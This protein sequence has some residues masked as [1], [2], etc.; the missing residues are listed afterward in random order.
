MLKRMLQAK[1][2]KLLASPC[3]TTSAQWH[4]VDI[5][6]VRDLRCSLHKLFLSATK[7]PNVLR[8]SG[9]GAF[10]D[11]MLDVSKG[12]P[13]LTGIGILEVAI[14]ASPF[15]DAENFGN[16]NS[17]TEQ[18]MRKEGRKEE[19]QQKCR[20]RWFFERG[21]SEKISRQTPRTAAKLIAS[22]RCAKR[23]TQMNKSGRWI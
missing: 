11:L 2:E 18:K 17:H 8:T 13:T 1:A 4:W 23:K 7:S 10:R 16:D 5:P 6:G 20:K 21:S 3:V 14:P 19:Q 9:H 12:M 22:I 15:P